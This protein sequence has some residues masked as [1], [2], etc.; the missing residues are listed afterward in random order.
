V[1]LKQT[2]FS[3]GRWTAVS[4]ILATATQML[5]IVILARLLL[6]AEFGLMAVA[7]AILAVLALI[8]DFGLSRTLIH[9]D[10]VSQSSLSSLYWLNVILALLLM[11]LLIVAAPA[12]AALYRSPALSPLL[13][14]ASLVFP[15]TAFGQQFQ[16]L[17][18]KELRFAELARIEV[19]AAVG[20][21][22]AAVAIGMAG[23]G[24]YALVAGLLARGA[25]SS[26]LAWL[27]LSHGH[28]PSW[29]L[30]LRETRPY[31]SFGGYLVG[32][33]FAN[34]I[35]AQADVFIGGLALSPS[36]MGIYSV[37]RDLSLRVASVIN[38]II[39]RVG[40]PVM[41]R[42]KHDR[43]RLKSI[44]LQTLRMTASVNFPLYVALGLFSNEIVALL[45]GSQWQEAATYLRVLAAWGL[46]RSTSNPVGSLLYAV[47]EAKRAFWWNIALLLLLPPLYWTGVHTGGLEG[48]AISVALIQ[49]LILPLAWMFLVNP[50]CNIRLGEYL[51]QLA[52]PLWIAL[53][54]GAMAWLATRGLNHSLLRLIAGGVA[55]GTSYVALSW[56]FNKP[57]K[58]AMFE[59]LDTRH[60][61]KT[62][63]AH[64]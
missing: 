15:L 56:A 55:G 42:V 17:A 52:V 1:S 57:W 38:P 4:A 18:Q 40:F 28:R 36:A 53:A 29:D 31:L 32:D 3:A 44:Y 50:C 64:S 21:L 54:S 39:T 20:G 25:V 37:P 27:W 41:S 62:W 47:G 5:Q 6:P 24:V 2:A 58:D 12:L 33:S 63:K 43:E 30:R 22:I 61:K 11:L 26:T 46:I 16:V 13:Q 23:G 14:A 10:N 51:R 7:A 45:Y 48:L 59:L 34:T 8:A 49:L 19:A 60:A 9:F 35:I